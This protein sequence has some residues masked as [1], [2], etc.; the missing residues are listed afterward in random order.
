MSDDEARGYIAESEGWAA[1]DTS[2]AP[3]GRSAAASASAAAAGSAGG[4]PAGWEQFLDAL[5]ERLERRYGGKAAQSR[6]T[7]PGDVMREI[8]E[9]LAMQRREAGLCIKCG[10]AKYE[11][12]SRGHNSRT[13]KA[14]ANKTTGV[15][16]EG[17]RKAG[18]SDF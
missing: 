6:R 7:V 11:P 15:G 8:P 2:G 12:G 14:P 16:N 13:C 3:A 5:D 9:Q 18:S 4:S 17:K 1:H 10:V